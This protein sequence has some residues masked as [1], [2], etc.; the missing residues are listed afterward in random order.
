MVLVGAE[1][2][3]GMDPAPGV[4]T[5]AASAG[6]V[7]GAASGTVVASGAVVGAPFGVVAAAAPTRRL[8][9]ASFLEPFWR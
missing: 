5:G 8:A 1:V 3:S 6:A 2:L 9:P 7:S 4:A